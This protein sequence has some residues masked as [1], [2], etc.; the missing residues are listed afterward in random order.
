MRDEGSDISE[1]ATI[2]SDL[3]KRLLEVQIFERGGL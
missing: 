2:I 3:H 1:D